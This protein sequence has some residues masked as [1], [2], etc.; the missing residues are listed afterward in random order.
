[1]ITALTVLRGVWRDLR[2][3]SKVG[4]VERGRMVPGVYIFHWRKDR[5]AGI[6]L[7]LEKSL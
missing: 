2:R 4:E 1:M 7:A 6:Y 5:L 3:I